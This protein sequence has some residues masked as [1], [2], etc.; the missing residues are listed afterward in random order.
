[1]R[2]ASW[3]VASHFRP[4]LLDATLS[5]LHESTVPPDW[6]LEIVV[7]Y[8]AND[9]LSGIIASSHGAT[10]VPTDEPHP[11]GKRNA[12]CKFA[13]G[14][15]LMATDD[16]DFQSP[17]RAFVAISAHLAGHELSGIREFRRLHLATGNIVR[18]CGRGRQ[19]DTDPDLPP[20][21]CGTAR[22]YSRRLLEKHGGW[23]PTMP[24]LEDSDLHRRI[25]HR[26]GTEVGVTEHDLGDVLADST[27]I[28]QHDANIFRERPE[29]GRGQKTVFG[30]YLIVG[31]GH[32]TQVPNFPA[33]V[34]RRLPGIL[35]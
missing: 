13:R 24:S 9:P 4:R 5:A 20:V 35:G 33:A 19:V 6:H 2:I 23:N 10:I 12:A 30:E 29:I 7:A 27:I 11:G 3:I 8:H 26:T 14:E 34:A 18:Y 16:D 32:Y 25:I 15:L 31:E 17:L 28:L 21:F 1:M 22:N